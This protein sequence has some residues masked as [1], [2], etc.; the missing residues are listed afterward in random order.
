MSEP[1][2]LGDNLQVDLVV[3]SGHVVAFVIAPVVAI[4]MQSW[5]WP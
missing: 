5:L 1:G 4:V 2:T 3:D